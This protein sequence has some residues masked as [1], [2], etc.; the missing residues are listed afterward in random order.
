MK[1]E[2]RSACGATSIGGLILANL[3]GFGS[4]GLAAVRDALDPAVRAADH[5]GVGDGGNAGST[6]G[7]LAAAWALL[8]VG[9]HIMRDCERWRAVRGEAAADRDDDAGPGR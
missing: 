2:T 4:E 6:L 1:Q 9:V 7:A 8:F 5:G 3:A